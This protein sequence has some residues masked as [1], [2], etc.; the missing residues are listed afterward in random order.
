MKFMLVP[1]K[2]KTNHSHGQNLSIFDT[3]ILQ[4]LENRSRTKNIGIDVLVLKIE[5]FKNRLGSWLKGA[6]W[7]SKIYNF[8]KRPVTPKSA[9]VATLSM[10]WGIFSQV[11]SILKR[12]EVFFVDFWLSGKPFLGF[13]V[14]NW[15]RRIQKSVK[16]TSRCFKFEIFQEKVP[17]YIRKII[18]KKN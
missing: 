13:L 6:K 15:L 12:L 7:F 8:F 10:Y 3:K 2:I 16:N 4:N 11:F 14:K 1:S 5:I 18:A 17:Q 9:T